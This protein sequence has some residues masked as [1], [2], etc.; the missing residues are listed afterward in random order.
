MAMLLSRR[1]CPFSRLKHI[2][3][4]LVQ[5]V[6]QSLNIDSFAKFQPEWA[7]DKGARISTWNNAENCLMTS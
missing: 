6:N 7:K 4:G 2:H 1:K 3:I 5:I